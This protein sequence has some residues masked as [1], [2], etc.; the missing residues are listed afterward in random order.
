MARK[1]GKFKDRFYKI[2]D[3][4]QEVWSGMHRWKRKADMLEEQ[5]DRRDEDYFPKPGQH[6]KPAPG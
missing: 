5:L 4:L 6:P 3:K 1:N 2:K